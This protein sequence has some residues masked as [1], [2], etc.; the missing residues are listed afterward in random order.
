VLPVIGSVS[1]SA[2]G[3]AG[4]GSGAYFSIYGSNFAAANAGIVTW[5]GWVVNGNLPSSLAG[6]SVTVGGQAAYIYA[7]SATQ[8]NALA[9]W[10]T[11]GPTQVVV[12]TAAG[13]GAPFVVN[14]ATLQPAIFTWGKYA[15][16]TRTDYSYAVPNGTLSVATTAAKAGEVVILWGTGFGMPAQRVPVGQEVPAAAFTVPNVSAT[17]ASTS[18]PVYGS[19]AAL[20]PGLAGVYQVAI[21]VPSGMA[22]G[23]YDLVVAVN[24][25]ASPAV[26]FAV[27]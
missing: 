27:Q 4:A 15:V 5:S 2:G 14:A 23:T 1:N 3:Q 6:V 7:V 21:T 18:I 25:V 20:A 12:T 8:I 9:P 24:G 22:S 19:T 26:S 13:N 17:L 10:L 16:A 11:A